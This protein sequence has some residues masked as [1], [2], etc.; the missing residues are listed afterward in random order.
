LSA[1]EPGPGPSGTEEMH[2]TWVPP[3]RVTVEQIEESSRAAVARDDVPVDVEEYLF[4]IESLG[5]QW[6]VGGAVYQPRSAV[7]TGADGRPVGVFLIH[8]GGGDH[9]GFDTMAR[10][11]ARTK[12]YRVVTITYP[13]NLYLGGDGYDWPGDTFGDDG[14]I[15]TPM[16]LKG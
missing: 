9:R 13:G 15:R 5:L 4:R 3:K 8:G 11:L 16:W 14:A 6:D 12:G 10:L 1:V 2:M 7:A